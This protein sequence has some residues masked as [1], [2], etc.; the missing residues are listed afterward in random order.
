MGTGNIIIIAVICLILLSVLFYTEGTVLLDL[1]EKRNRYKNIAFKLVSVGSVNK[2]SNEA[3]VS[4]GASMFEDN[5]I[6]VDV[7]KYTFFVVDGNSMD[8]FGL[9][10]GS[11]VLVDNDKSWSSN[12]DTVF[13]I[14][15]DNRDNGNKIEYKLR[16]A[17]D[18]Y[19]CIYEDRA[20]F[21]VWVKNHPELN[22]GELYEKYEK[23]H[24][25]IEECKRFRRR[26]LVS[27]TTRDGK[28]YYSFHPENSI[29]GKVKYKIPKETVKIIEKR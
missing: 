25:K 28:P 4:M 3:I 2:T 14:K 21:D 20:T 23:E 5:G 17:I 18:F 6:Q 12:G 26:L 9:K 8:R 22:A 11:I 10:D 1:K 19:D 13:V 24:E 7:S 15:I 16:K 27:E 29:Y